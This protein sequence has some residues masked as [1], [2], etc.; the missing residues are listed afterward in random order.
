MRKGRFKRLALRNYQPGDGDGMRLF[1]LYQ[2]ALQPYIE[3][4]L[5][6]DTAFQLERFR[7]AYTPEA[8]KLIFA[9]NAMAG[10]VVLKD[11]EHAL[12]VAL[13]VLRRKFRHQ[14]IGTAVMKI[15]HKSAAAQ[16]KQVTLSCFRNN[17]KALRFY[18]DLGYRIRHADAVF[19]DLYLPPL[20]TELD[21]SL[22]LSA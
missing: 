13:L 6:W 3:A 1:S 5:G 17:A 7:R 18:L 12:H 21:Q 19:Y 20:A 8:T 15:I 14:G 16:G 10:Y 4:S 9:D 22:P 11:T 2:S